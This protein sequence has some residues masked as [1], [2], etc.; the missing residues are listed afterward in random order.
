MDV[1]IGC[2]AEDCAK[3]TVVLAKYTFVPRRDAPIRHSTLENARDTHQSN[4]QAIIA[5]SRVAQKVPPRMEC[6]F[7]MERSIQL[8]GVRWRDV[9]GHGERAAFVFG[10]GPRQSAKLR[11]ALCMLRRREFVHD[12]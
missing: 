5:K 11:D 9:I 7:G 6:V 10:M 3:N 1:P 4:R 2:V 12:T 8:T